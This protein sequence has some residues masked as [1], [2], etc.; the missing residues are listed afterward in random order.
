[1]SMIQSIIVVIYY[2]F[3]DAPIVQLRSMGAF[4][5]WV[6]GSFDTNP[7]SQAYLIYS[8]T[9]MY[10]QVVLQKALISFSGKWYLRDQNI[11]PKGSQC[12]RVIRSSLKS[13]K[14]IYSFSFEKYSSV[15]LFEHGIF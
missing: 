9:H 4:S 1:M 3:S 13:T 2:C 5:N 6:L 15:K 11:Y 12:Y 10:N 7:S 8:L 14:T